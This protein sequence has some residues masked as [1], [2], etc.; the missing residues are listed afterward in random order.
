MKYSADIMKK[1]VTIATRYA[2]VRRQHTV[3]GR[4]EKT[5]KRFA[6]PIKSPVHFTHARTQGRDRRSGSFYSSLDHV[7]SPESSF[8]CWIC[9]RTS[10]VCSR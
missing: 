6:P 1:A 3:Q 4:D 10:C 8:T 9:N 7:N 5:G 2:A